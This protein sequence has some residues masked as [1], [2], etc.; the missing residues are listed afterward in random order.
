[1]LADFNGVVLAG[2]QGKYGTEFITWDWDHNHKG[3]SHGHYFID[4]YEGAK[5]ESGQDRFGPESKGD[6]FSDRQNQME[7]GS[8]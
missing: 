5:Q 2:V 4:T 8:D 6:S 3:A 1:M 7:P